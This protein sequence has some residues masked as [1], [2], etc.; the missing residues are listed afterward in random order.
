MLIERYS[1][2]P[3]DYIGHMNDLFLKFEQ[4]IDS[5]S[6]NGYLAVLVEAMEKEPK[7]CRTLVQ[8]Y[9]KLLTTSTNVHIIKVGAWVLGE[10]TS[11]IVEDVQSIEEIVMLLIAVFSR[12]V[13]KD[14]VVGWVVP[15]V[16][17]LSQTEH[18]GKHEQ[19]K[20][21][22]LELETSRN[23]RTH[24]IAEGTRVAM[25]RVYSTRQVWT[26]LAERTGPN[27]RSTTIFPGGICDW[28]GQTSK[29]SAKR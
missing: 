15:A 6:I 11:K 25:R 10:Y 20:Q 23:I 1:S 19:V 7:F 29:L 22:L 24:N 18:F 28:I 21:F 3:D 17:K 9:S 13:E 26:S 8:E 5:K 14:Q 16:I 27:G 12:C 4:V 2:T